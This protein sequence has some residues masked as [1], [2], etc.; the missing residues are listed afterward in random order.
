MKL[1]VDVIRNPGETYMLLTPNGF[2]GEW[3]KGQSRALTAGTYW[4]AVADEVTQF[5]GGGGGGLGFT[6]NARVE[7]FEHYQFRLAVAPGGQPGNNPA[8]VDLTATLLGINTNLGMGGGQSNV[9][10][11]GGTVMMSFRVNNNGPTPTTAGHYAIY[12][13]KTPQLTPASKFVVFGSFFDAVP[14]MGST[15]AEPTGVVV[16]ADVMPGNYFMIVVANYD[17]SVNETNFNNNAS[18]P[19]PITIR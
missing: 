8:T 4:L 11:P 3:P 13:S 7:N 15:S 16:P 10:A 5:I 9:T 2:S 19:A 12:I 14:A 17:Q 18:N 6:R 1:E